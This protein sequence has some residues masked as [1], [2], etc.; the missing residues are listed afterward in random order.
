MELS[1]HTPR[2]S[3]GLTVQVEGLLLK[4]K[5]LE[6][7]LEHAIQNAAQAVVVVAKKRGNAR[8]ITTGKG[9]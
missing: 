8:T 7:Q 2:R 1:A 3:D 5:M 4:D 9:S 6:S